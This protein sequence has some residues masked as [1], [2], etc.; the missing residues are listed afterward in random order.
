IVAVRRRAA[1]FGALG[2][3]I[4][5]SFFFYFFVDVVDH[6]HAYVGWR[7]GHFLFIAFAPLIGF[8]WQ[9]LRAGGRGPRIGAVIVTVVLAAAAAPMTII[10]LYNAQDTDFRAR[11]PGFHWTDI[12]T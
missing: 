2:L 12:V 1:R 8:A 11:W 3:A 5:V 9:E 7:A 6:Q 4:A 10:D